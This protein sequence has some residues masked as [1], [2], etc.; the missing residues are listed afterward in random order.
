MTSIIDTL[1]SILSNLKTE[2]ESV[3]TK[4]KVNI[5]LRFPTES[6][7]YPIALIVPIR[8]TPTYA[9]GL[10]QNDEYA[11]VEIE[12]HL[13]TKV[14]FDFKGSTL[15]TDLDTALEKLRTLRYDD[16]KWREL[17]YKTG[18][19]FAYTPISNWILQ[20]AVVNLTIEE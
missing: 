10:L 15:L 19:E 4:Y 7:N 17:Q 5:F 8:V 1:S 6:D 11:T 16:T 18:I 13:I 2:I 14:P 20:S 12:L 3:L 9:G